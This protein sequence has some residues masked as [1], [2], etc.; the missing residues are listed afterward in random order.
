MANPVIKL[1]G[2]PIY[3]EQDK[4]AE[5]ILP[6]HLIT[7]DSNG[8][9]IKHNVAG[10]FTP[11]VFATEREEMGDDIDVAYAV[12]DKVK[13]AH[14]YPGCRVAVLIASGQNL[15]KGDF[16]ESAGDGTMRKFAAGTRIGR[17]MEVTGAVVALSR[18]AMEV[19]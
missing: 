13:S 3:D 11:A 4:A 15:I 17:S 10:G 14:F 12:G 2:E 18:V 6:G 16:M 5:A 8:D 1:R 7:F 9:W 19:I